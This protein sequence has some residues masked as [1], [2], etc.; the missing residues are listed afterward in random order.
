MKSSVTLRTQKLKSKTLKKPLFSLF[1]DIYLHG[2]RIRE[3]LN[4]YVSQEYDKPLTKKGVI[5]TTEKG[6]AKFPTVLKE[7]KEAWE[8]AKEMQRQRETEIVIEQNTELRAIKSR[9]LNF[10]DFCEKYLT[11][12][13]DTHKS[14]FL[15][16]LKEAVG[17][18]IAYKDINENFVYL[19]CEFLNEQDLKAST[20]AQYLNVINKC[21][22]ALLKKGYIKKNPFANSLDFQNI[23]M[24]VEQ[25]KKEYLTFEELQILVANPNPKHYNAKIENAFFFACFTGLRISDIRALKWININFEQKTV[26]IRQQKTS[27]LLANPLHEQAI[28]ILKNIGS[29]GLYVFELPSQVYVNK[30][31][32]E[33]AVQAG[34]T[35]DI[36]FHVSRHSFATLQ[37]SNGTDLYTVSKMLGHANITQTQVYA[38]LVD[39]KKREA[40]NNMPSLF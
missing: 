6:L 35:K 26:Y 24:K 14:G 32:K 20:K 22:N 4:L 8:L 40:I 39:D 10:I 19:L 7:D 34:I 25:A 17:N 5:V 31:L 15:D 9:N 28:K 23:K 18:Y 21:V 13:R 38:K 29:K 11:E 12:K 2:K 36:S 27:G 30:Y 33:W 1:L 37:L 16:L 3:F